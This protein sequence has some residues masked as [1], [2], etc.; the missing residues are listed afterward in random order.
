M[1][2]ELLGELHGAKYFSKIDSRAYYHQIRMYEPDI[3]NN[4]RT[5][6]GNYEFLVMTFG[7]TNAT[8]FQYAINSM[9]KPFLRRCVLVFLDD[10]FAEHGKTTFTM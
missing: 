7:L 9:L 2:E 5:H 10:I 3:H 1:V 6:Q 8:T 4:F